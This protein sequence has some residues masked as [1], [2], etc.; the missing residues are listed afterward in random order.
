MWPRGV[1]VHFQNLKAG[2]EP[3]RPIFF[4][5]RYVNMP[6]LVHALGVEVTLA[7]FGLC[8]I[9][10]AALNNAELS[11]LIST[12]AH[13]HLLGDLKRCTAEAGC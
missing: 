4:C 1:E 3:F 8:R 7:L 5:R 2:D 12:N 13:L 10:E 9:A 6:G 11:L